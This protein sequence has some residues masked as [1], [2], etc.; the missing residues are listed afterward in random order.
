MFSNFRNNDD[1]YGCTEDFLANILIECNWYAGSD[2]FT[3][4]VAEEFNFL[5][6]GTVE[7]YN[8]ERRSYHFPEFHCDFSDLA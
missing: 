4:F 5:E 1:D 3:V 8:S 7:I 6:D 2:L